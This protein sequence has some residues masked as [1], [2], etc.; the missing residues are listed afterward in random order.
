MFVP[1]DV[2][3]SQYNMDSICSL[4]RSQPA[5]NTNEIDSLNILNCNRW[6][7]HSTEVHQISV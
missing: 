4:Y 7:L 6:Q 3:S 5:L 2:L 1:G